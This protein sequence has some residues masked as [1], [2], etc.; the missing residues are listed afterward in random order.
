[1]RE[2]P[3]EFDPDAD[4]FACRFYHH[5]IATLS[6]CEKVLP[7]LVCCKFRG[8]VVDNIDPEGIG[9]LKVSV[10]DVLGGED[11]FAM[12]SL[13]YA[14]SGVGPPRTRIEASTSGIG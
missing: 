5:R 1:M 6:P 13:P 8:T 2:E 4:T 9:R 10:P 11:E 14:G 12:P 7:Q 3:P